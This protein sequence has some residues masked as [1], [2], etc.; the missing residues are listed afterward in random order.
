VKSVALLGLIALVLLATALASP[1]VAWTLPRLVGHEF[2]FARVYDRV[3]E[4]LLAVAVL[5]AWRRLDI[6]T[7]RE[8]GFRR[9]GWV[10]ELARGLA[11]GLVGIAV[12]LVACA[13]LGALAPALRFPP[14]KTVGKALQ[15]IAAAGAIAVGEEALFRGVLLRRIGR[16]LGKITAVVLTTVIY[17]AVHVVRAR[18]GPD[19]IDA[20]AGIAYTGTLFAPLGRLAAAPELLGLVLLGALLMTARLQSGALWLP[21]GVHAAFVIGFRVGRLFFEIAPGP[22]WLVGSGWPPLIGGAAGWLAVAVAALLLS[23]TRIRGRRA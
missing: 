1:W 3:F 16:D 6:G 19:A 8:I 4:V 12:A 18:G 13:L 7:A 20:G 2:G 22:A 17:A 10:R 9:Q 14:L 23:R 15:G 21:I 11:V 5:L